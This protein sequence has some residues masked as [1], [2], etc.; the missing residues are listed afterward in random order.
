MHKL[1]ITH[2]PPLS[3]MLCNLLFYKILLEKPATGHISLSLHNA[4]IS[5]YLF[6]NK[7]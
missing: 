4:C 1:C 3:L 5:S 7:S 2:D 6:E